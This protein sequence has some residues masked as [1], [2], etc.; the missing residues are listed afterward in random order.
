MRN[1]LSDHRFI[2][3]LAATALVGC[4]VEFDS[5]GQ[6]DGLRILG[7]QQDPSVAQPGDTVNMRMVVHDT[8]SLE[9]ERR[10]LSYLWLGGCDNPPGDAYFGCLAKFGAVA[11]GLSGLLGT[12]PS[13]LTP[14]Q[15]QE[16]QTLLEQNGVS[17]GFGETFAFPIA[18]DIL[19]N[20]P[21]TSL[22]SKVPYGVSF[23]F[24][25]ACAGELRPDPES[26]T[27]PVACFDGDERLGP[28]DFVAGYTSTYTYEDQRNSL[29]V[30]E[31]I[32]IGGK[33]VSSELI[34]IGPECERPEPD[35]ERKCPR[36]AP[37][38][39]R[40]ESGTMRQS[41]PKTE[42]VVRVDPDSVDQDAPL[43]LGGST[44]PE[45]MWVNYHTDH[46][47]FANDL[48]LVNDVNVGFRDNPK[49]DFLAP[50]EPGPAFVWAAVR[51]SRG[52]FA[53]ARTTICVE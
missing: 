15:L 23:T 8:G 38:V 41:C 7:V 25:A 45:P 24:F 40:C 46:G 51:D 12:D 33:N 11:E 21:P 36:G 14:D 4:G 16:L 19:R 48:A 35:P 31:G 37:R 50:E 49:T 26:E 13:E 2:P 22:P 34:C 5:I 10:D 44:A 3:L 53:W 20:K 27:F 32:R 39:P 30:I 18:E 28:R 42:V 9:R 6:L 47:S 29:P 43:A 52:G 1:L 17:L